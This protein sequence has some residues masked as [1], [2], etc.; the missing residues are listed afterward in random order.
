[1]D[2]RSGV[3]IAIP[4]SAIGYV[5]GQP[6]KL[7]MFVSG[8]GGFISNQFLPGL[9]QNTGN[10]GGNERNI[11][12]NNIPGTQFATFTPANVA[13]A[14]LV[15]GFMDDGVTAGSTGIYG[16]A[17]AVQTCFTGF[18]NSN[19]GNAVRSTNGSELNGLYVVRN[20]ATSTLYV[21]VA[22]NLENNGNRLNIFIDSIAGGQNRILNTTSGFN[23]LLPNLGADAS[24]TNG[25]TFDTGFEAD[26]ALSI[27]CNFAA[28]PTNPQIFIDWATFPTELPPVGSFIGFAGFPPFGPAPTFVL[29]AGFTA[30]AATG[31]DGT[32]DVRVAI[33]NRNT[34]GVLGTPVASGPSVA[35]SVDLAY[36]SEFN[37]VYSRVVGDTLFVMV[38][39]N[40]ETSFNKASFFF[41]VGPGGQQRLRGE[42]RQL[43]NVDPAP[44]GQTF[45][46]GL[47]APT[48]YVGNPAGDFSALQRLGGGND[49]FVVDPADNTRAINTGGLRF[50]GGFA[51]DYWLS[52]G[53]GGVDPIDP[54]NTV[55]MFSNAAVLRTNGRREATSGASTFSMDLESFDGGNKNGPNVN[56]VDFAG[57]NTADLVDF[58]GTPT[59]GPRGTRVA[60]RR[61]ADVLLTPFAAAETGLIDVKLN[62]SNVLGVSDTTA[63]DTAASAVTTGLEFSIKLNEL[64]WDGVSPIRM[65]GFISNG[66]YDFISNQVIG[67][68][69]P[70][71][72]T[73][74]ANLGEPRTT[75]LS[76]LPGNVW[77]T[78][79]G[80][81]PVACDSRANVAGA[82]Q[83]TTPDDQ[84]TAD[85]IIVFL[86]WYFGNTTG[87]PVAGNPASPANLLADVSGANQNASQ[88][89]GQLTAD[90]II[91]FLGFYF[92]GCP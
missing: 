73:S 29:P 25:F 11:N 91:V 31:G 2:V 24:N 17:V 52:V 38:T 57:P 8:G 9:P 28:A 27:N 18:G 53:T 36:G 14:P 6:L 78:L 37:A 46:A 87:A 81:G 65:T 47:L 21:M 82:N 88:P 19:T 42:T 69:L 4:Y 45:V 58:V 48:R 75:D 13:T 59:E 56:L 50:D 40:L 74:Q 12:L 30:L 76:T 33:D 44:D 34:G 89:D 90:D 7:S 5:A 86:G 92:Q 79:V 84:L 43:T 68:R 15:D 1:A 71:G 23:G 64:G 32:P 72:V 62:N 35:P 49:T 51:A 55:S 22:G 41:D 77:V 85:D 54:I 20:D 66:G 26:Y 63:T 10:V 83:S 61:N 60:P 80:T 70:T 39:G 67:L 3:E 16:A